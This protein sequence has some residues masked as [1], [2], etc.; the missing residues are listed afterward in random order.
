VCVPVDLK[1][2]VII[3]CGCADLKRK[4]TKPFSTDILCE[5]GNGRGE[6]GIIFSI[7][8]DNPCRDANRITDCRKFVGKIYR[9]ARLRGNDEEKSDW[10][11]GLN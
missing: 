1:E 2:I 6:S 5:S 7:L 8:L 9:H 10:C 4:S 11:K 3:L